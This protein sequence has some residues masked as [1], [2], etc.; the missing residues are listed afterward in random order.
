MDI[1]EIVILAELQLRID[2]YELPADCEAFDR[3]MAQLQL[4]DGALLSVA[5]KLLGG[6]RYAVTTDN[7]ETVR[8]ALA[9]ARHVGGTAEVQED[10]RFTHLL[11]SP[12]AVQ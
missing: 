6:K 1:D 3:G 5:A 4:G 9:T 2:R 8:R 12:P 7:P 11:F 10:G